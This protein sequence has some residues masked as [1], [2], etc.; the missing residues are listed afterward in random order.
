MRVPSQRR[1]LPVLSQRKHMTAPGGVQAVVRRPLRVLV[2]SVGLAVWLGASTL[3]A[4]TH[5]PLP[6]PATTPTPTPPPT[7]S[8]GA[9][10]V[11]L[12]LVTDDKRAALYAKLP[13]QL[14]LVGS[15]PSD[16]WEIVCSAP[17]GKKVDPRRMYRVI[18]EGLEPS[19]DFNLAPGAGALTLAVDPHLRST[20]TVGAVLGY[21][22]LASMAFGGVLI[23]AGVAEA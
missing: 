8:S 15:E 10:W 18:G 20:R 14:A 3:H 11:A 2:R 4:Q 21:A 7:A 16:A 12:T 17:C 9:D 5:G 19:N 23:I 6:P 13:G 22:G 1:S